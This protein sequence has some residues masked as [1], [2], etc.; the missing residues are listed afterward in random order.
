MNLFRAA[1]MRRADQAAAEAGV[2][3]V[4]L[5]ENAGRAVAEA[6]QRYYPNAKRVA[7]VCGKG[8]N[9]GD[10]YVAAR[11]LLE[12]GGKVRVYEQAQ[13][14]D[15][16]GSPE[17]RAARAAYRAHEGETRPLEQVLEDDLAHFDLIIDALLGSGL[18]RPLTGTMVSCVTRVN[19]SHVPVLSIDVP[20]GVDAD[21]ARAPGTHVRAHATVQ[22]AGAKYASALHP[23]CEAFGRWEVAAIGIP[24]RIL[25]EHASAQL[26]D[27]TTVRA[28]MPA[29]ARDAH[30]Y[31]VGTVLVIAGSTRYLGAAELACRGA[32]RAGAGLVTLAAEARLAGGWPEAV[33]SP[34]SWDEE[35]LEQLAAIDPKR[36][37]ARVIGPGLD[38]RALRWLP[39]LIS[40]S[41]APTVLDAEALAGDDAWLEAVRSHGRCVLT[42]HWGEAKRLLPPGW[43]G[44][45][46]V[47]A[48]RTIAERCGAV[49]VLK[50]AT[51][52]I[53]APD[54]RLALSTKGHPGMATGG[55][56]DVLAGV[57]G[58]FAGSS[59]LFTRSCAAVYLHGAAGERAGAR[60]GPGLLPSDIIEALPGGLVDTAE[61]SP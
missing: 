16:M 1:E 6:A 5:M 38:E 61:L 47:A 24:A 57:L 21:A 59:D 19:D 51:T 29:R 36:R 45:D 22:L 56:G 50:G 7:V 58:A 23:A 35:P 46:P 15:E 25:A 18:T 34:L 41:E 8:N 2:P 4:V 11:H 43:E 52:V 30:K 9:G 27:E 60:Y 55:T 42:P 13:S 12:S 39:R 14:D 33:F 48:A 40:Q 26:L 37:Q 32:L 53:A 3:L 54:G 44:D 10:G 49:T 20:T 17:A 31:Q 28:W